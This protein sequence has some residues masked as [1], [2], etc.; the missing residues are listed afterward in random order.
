MHP[1]NRAAKSF[2]VWSKMMQ[3]SSRPNNKVETL[4]DKLNNLADEISEGIINLGDQSRE[5]VQKELSDLRE[6]AYKERS[7]EAVYNTYLFRKYANIANQL[8]DA[9]SG[10]KDKSTFV[11]ELPSFV[12]E[13]DDEEMLVGYQATKSN[14]FRLRFLVS[15]FALI[16]FSVMSSA[17][18]VDRATFNPNHYFKVSNQLHFT[19]PHNV[20]QYHLCFYT[21]TSYLYGN[22]YR[23][24]AYL[25]TTL[26]GRSTSA[27][28]SW[29]WPWAYWPGCTA[30]TTCS[31]TSC[32]WTRTSRN[33]SQVRDMFHMY[34]SVGLTA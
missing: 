9:K 31:T 12:Y 5:N 3:E 22:D 14:I 28:T 30:S 4:Y 16:T 15:I 8:K 24:N 20:W 32:L 23:T 2:F 33:I 17:S 19:Y 10:Q 21:N 29:W 34:I 7:P 11:G 18:Y 25:K 6:L 1:H 13:A 26:A 27:P